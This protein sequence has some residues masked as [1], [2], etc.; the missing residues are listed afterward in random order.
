MFPCGIGYLK[1][2]G[3]HL[4]NQVLNGGCRVTARRLPRLIFGGSLYLILLASTGYR[5][6][7]AAEADPQAVETVAAQVDALFEKSWADK[8]ITP[9]PRSDDA[10]FLRRTY[11]N[12]AGRIPAVAEA[13][14][15]LAETSPAKRG[16]LVDRL[17]EG[18]GY[19]RHFANVWRSAYLPELMT[20]ANPGLTPERFD[21]WIRDHL[22]RNSPYDRMV[23]E[24]ILMPE[25]GAQGLRAG[26]VL[27]YQ[28][29][30][31]KP[32]NAAAG[33]ARSILGVRLECA[34]CHDH[35]FAK[36]KQEEFWSQAAFF[37]DQLLPA[38]PGAT[39]TP[40]TPG[41]AELKIPGKEKTVAAR[42]LRGEAPQLTP[43]RPAREA[44]V[45]WIVSP[46]NPYFARAAVNRIWRE[47]FGAGIVNPVDDLDEQNPPSHPEVLELLANEFTKSRYDLKHLIRIIGR[48]K[49]SQ[50]SSGWTDDHDEREREFARMRV[51]PLTVD[52]LFDTLSQA[53]GYYEPFVEQGMFAETPRR[54]IQ[55]IFQSESAEGEGR[56]S[57]LQALALMNGEFVSQAVEVEQSQTLAGIVEAPFLDSAGKVRALYL[58]TLTRLPTDEELRE[59]T[60]F[61]AEGKSDSERSRRYGDLFWMLLNCSEFVLNH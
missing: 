37:A 21:A 14:E 53:T 6:L 49:A 43:N 54:K 11:L 40:P 50:L 30:E 39:S 60:D 22:M 36:W 4:L 47:L 34:Q 56:T 58:A 20:T 17:L 16:D 52:Q 1:R 42:Y 57:I 24:L 19:V 61:V 2:I 18:P 3:N 13:Q 51:R 48:T 35:P 5:T 32:E 45:E 27:F 15:F 7:H 29:K 10:E 41:K 26:T 25:P 23:R 59:A 28:A 31:G 9:A 12:L 44:L 33:V 38:P 46:D 55:Q 8:K